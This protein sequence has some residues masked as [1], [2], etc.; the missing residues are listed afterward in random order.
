M[1]IEITVPLAVDQASVNEYWNK[2]RYKT[3]YERESDGLGAIDSEVIQQR[4][5]GLKQS[6]DDANE[7]IKAC[8]DELERREIAASDDAR[9]NRRAKRKDSVPRKSSRSKE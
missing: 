6:I 1:P 2:Q 3:P 8:E 5:K 7:R 9:K 4:I